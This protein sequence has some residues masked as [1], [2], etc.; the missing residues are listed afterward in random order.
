[1]EEKKERKEI[2]GREIRGKTSWERDRVCWGEDG[3]EEIEHES[4]I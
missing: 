1:M 2:R 4:Y 3:G